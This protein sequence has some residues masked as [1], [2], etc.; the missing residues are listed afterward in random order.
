LLLILEDCHW[1]DPL[2]HDLLEVLGRTIVDLPVVLVLAYRPPELER[3]QA[4]RVSQLPY[5]TEISLAD[6]TPQEAE[7]L[8]TL[9]LNQFFGPQTKCLP[10]WWNEYRSR[11]GQPF[12]LRS[13]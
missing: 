13:C 2:S 7:R 6:F 12:L 3:L 10:A 9:K 1:L 8:I 4:P 5:F 11:P